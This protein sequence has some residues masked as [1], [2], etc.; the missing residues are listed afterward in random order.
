[1]DFASITSAPPLRKILAAPLMVDT[2]YGPIGVVLRESFPQYISKFYGKPSTLHS[3]HLIYS[4]FTGFPFI[5]CSA[6]WRP[7]YATID[8]SILRF[9]WNTP[10]CWQLVFSFSSNGNIFANLE[11]VK[12]WLSCGCSKT[13]WRP[14]DRS[15][16]DRYTA[17]SVN[18]PTHT[19]TVVCTL[20][21]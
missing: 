7:R 12:F 13:A 2:T 4:N 3:I 21:I 18:P 19:Q 14:S 15:F 8:S 6:L 9:L 5:N 17:A 16:D 10:N 11:K 1:M 20:N